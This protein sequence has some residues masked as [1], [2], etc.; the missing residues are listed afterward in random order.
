MLDTHDAAPCAC[1]FN[2][3]SYLAHLGF[4]AFGGARFFFISSGFKR[5]RYFRDI[6]ISRNVMDEGTYWMLE[7]RPNCE[8]CDKDLPPD[9][10]DARICSY[11]CTYCAE[12]VGSVLHNVCPTCGGGFTHRP[13]RPKA[14][15]RDQLTLCLLYT[16]D[17]A[18]E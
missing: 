6:E 10:A 14:A 1:L 2:R 5:L 9:A 18:D 17:A 13:I 3:R 7:L 4:M 11:E 16:S 12:C 15:H 8:W